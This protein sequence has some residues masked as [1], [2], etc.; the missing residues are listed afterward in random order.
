MSTTIAPGLGLPVFGFWATPVMA[1][2]F[3]LI[4]ISMSVANRSHSRRSTAR[5]VEAR[6][7]DIY[8]TKSGS[9]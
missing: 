2:A 9:L 4:T 6:G 7:Q 3:G 1:A 8:L 5:H